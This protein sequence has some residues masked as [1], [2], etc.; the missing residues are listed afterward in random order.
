MWGYPRCGLGAV[1]AVLEPFCGHLSPKIDKVS[2]KLTFEIPPRRTL[3]GHPSDTRS[4]RGPP[5]AVQIFSNVLEGFEDASRFRD[6][7]RSEN[8]P[9]KLVTPEG[10]GQLGSNCPNSKALVNFVQGCG[11]G[12]DQKPVSAL[13]LRNAPQ[14]YPDLRFRNLEVG[15]NVLG[16]GSRLSYLLCKT[17]F[18]ILQVSDA[19]WFW[20]RNGPAAS[21]RAD[22][23]KRTPAMTGL[24]VSS[25]SLLYHAQT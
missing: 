2:W 16:F 10:N 18:F 8:L 3:G 22:P 23:A 9:K 6:E 17:F 5:P 21:Q 14:R 1:G 19:Q 15:F 20:M 7:F 24:N 25:S 4:S 13:I 12:L 11:C